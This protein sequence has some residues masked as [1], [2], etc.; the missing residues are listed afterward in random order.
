MIIIQ[1]ILATTS[2]TRSNNNLSFD[3]HFQFRISTFLAQNIFLNKSNNKKV[4]HLII[5]QSK[6]LKMNH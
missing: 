1:C 6:L 4:T 5:R 3:N 2:L